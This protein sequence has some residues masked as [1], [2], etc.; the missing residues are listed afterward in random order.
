MSHHDHDHHNDNH[1]T[2]ATIPFDK[3]MVKLLEHWIKHNADHAETYREWAGKAKDN[4]M[5]NIFILL[6]EA[7]AITEEINKKFK[8]ALKLTVL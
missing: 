8:K 6:E 1:E 4:D 3:K 5:K 7:V 2:N